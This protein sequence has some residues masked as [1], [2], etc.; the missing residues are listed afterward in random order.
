VIVP[1][2]RAPAERRWLAHLT[3]AAAGVIRAGDRFDDDAPFDADAVAALALRHRVAPLLHRGFESGRIADPVPAGFRAR[4]RGLYWATLRKSAVAVEVGSA[5][6]AELRAAGVAAAPLKGLALLSGPGAVYDD[7]GTRPMDDVDVI[8]ARRDVDRAVA[9]LERLGFAVATDRRQARLA[10]GH[11]LALHRRVGGVDLFLELHWAWAGPESLLRSFALP[12][13]RF[14]REHCAPDGQGGLAPTR[15]GHLLFVA[16]HAARHAFGRWLWLLDLHRLV[17]EPAPD[18]DA[19]L[20]GARGLRARRPL[21]AGLAASRELLRSP[22]PKEVLTA[23]A[24]GPV[25]RSLL[26]RSL[27]ASEARPASR[28]RGRVAKL[29]LGESWWDVARTAAWAAA[30][31]PAWYAERRTHPPTR[32]SARPSGP[33]AGISGP[34]A[35]ISGA[36]AGIGAAPEGPERMGGGA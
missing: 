6:L 10:G 7:P 31:G 5:A 30:P 24:P 14:L 2:H 4:C 26:H 1:S 16:V 8:V 23:L 32:P 13:E 15:V 28:S 29:L 33:P 36:P 12:G 20:A 18:W 19:V 25:R 17:E 9:V 27:A 35:G 22:V 21:Y 11:E 34:P 3:R